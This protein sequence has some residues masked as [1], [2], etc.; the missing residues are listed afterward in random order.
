MQQAPNQCNSILPVQFISTIPENLSV[1]GNV[2]EVV[3]TVA[4]QATF[5]A[6]LSAS[7]QEIQNRFL[8]APAVLHVEYHIHLV[9]CQSLTFPGLLAHVWVVIHNVV[10]GRCYV[11]KK[12]KKYFLKIIHAHVGHK[13]VPRPG[14]LTFPSSAPFG[15]FLG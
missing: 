12:R 3:F 15:R 2:L 14:Q 7:Q 11:V 13:Y 10:F 9:L 5:R 8:T 4:K 6:S 1:K